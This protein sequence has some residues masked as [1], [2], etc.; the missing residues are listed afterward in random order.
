MELIIPEFSS[1]RSATREGGYRLSGSA[2]K[3]RPMFSIITVVYNGEKYIEHTIKSVLA[4]S[5]RNIEHIVIDG[6]STDGT[7]RIIEEYSDRIAYWKS[8]KDK[9]I[10]D[11]MNKGISASSGEIIGT[12]N[13][14]D[15][16]SHEDVIKNIAEIFLRLAPDCVFGNVKF[17]DPSSNKVVRLYKSEDRPEARFRWGFMPAHPTFFV[18]K[19]DYRKY[20]LYKTDYKIAADYELIMRYI[21]KNKLSYRKIDEDL[22]VMRMGGA[23]T[24]G[25]RSLLQLNK[26]IIRACKEN[27]VYTNMFFLSLKYFKK[28]RELGGKKT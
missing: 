7:L 13:A 2:G 8:E 22:V 24:Q 3:D 11:G 20:G 16:Y 17:I 28:L 12:L 4:Q 19:S 9:G 25:I 23:S 1:E 6:G 15:Y 27:G 5:Y 26:E 14:D 18:R 10:Y 21:Y